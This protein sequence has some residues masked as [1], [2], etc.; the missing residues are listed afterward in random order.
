MMLSSMFNEDKQI[1]MELMLEI[2][3]MIEV[4]V[5]VGTKFNNKQAFDLAEGLGEIY[6]NYENNSR[7]H[8]N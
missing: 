1:R 3:E 5:R 8:N 4:L 7:L 6:L 2:A